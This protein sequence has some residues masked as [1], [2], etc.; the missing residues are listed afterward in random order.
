M[1]TA[2]VAVGQFQ[3]HLADAP[4]RADDVQR[5]K[6]RGADQHQYDERADN[7]RDLGDLIYF[8]QQFAFTQS[9]EFVGYATSLSMRVLTS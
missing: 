6:N 8:R 4:D 2:P 9:R 7:E 3:Q 5:R 1:S